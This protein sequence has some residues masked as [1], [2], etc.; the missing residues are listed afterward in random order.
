[1]GACFVGTLGVF[2]E[3]V[4]TGCLV[5]AG[6]RDL[7][8]IYCKYLIARS[9]LLPIVKVDAGEGCATASDRSSTTRRAASAEERDGT[10]QSCGK[11]SIVLMTRSDL[12]LGTYTV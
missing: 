8:M 3:M 2:G 12:V 9:C 11:N 1:M 6:G 5:V 4:D 7:A 10:G